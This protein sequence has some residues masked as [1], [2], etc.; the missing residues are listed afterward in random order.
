MFHYVYGL[1]H[2]EDYRK[3]FA[4]DLQKSLPRIPLVEDVAAFRAFAAAGRKLAVLHLSYETAEPCGSL[5]VSGKDA[6]PAVRQMKFGK[7]DGKTDRSVILFNDAI[8]IENVPLRAYEWVVNGKSPVE[9]LME[10][11][12]VTVNKDSQIRNDPNDWCR[13]HNSPRYI[14]DLVRR[15]VTVSLKTLDVVAALPKLDFAPLQT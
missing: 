4:A 9:W 8:K 12:A 7:R 5:I 15:I 14:L 13:E 6:A 10:R 11:Y 3:R 2:S 1:L